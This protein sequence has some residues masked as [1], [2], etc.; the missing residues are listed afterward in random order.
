VGE[1][2]VAVPPLD[3]GNTPETSAVREAWLMN[4]LPVAVERTKPAVREERVVE[5]VTDR[6]PDMATFCREESPDTVK[7]VEEALPKEAPDN[8]E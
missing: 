5:L 4:K 6:V 3:M 2:V 7:P 8:Q 1:A